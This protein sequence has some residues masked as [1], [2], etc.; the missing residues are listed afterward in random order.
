MRLC[1]SDGVTPTCNSS[2]A[3]RAQGCKFSI[4][5][6]AFQG[7]IV[8]LRVGSE[9]GCNSRSYGVVHRRHQR[10]RLCI[11]DMHAR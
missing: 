10:V 5:L 7:L 11:V 2:S 4:E 9:R 1:T 3:T 8:S 6:K